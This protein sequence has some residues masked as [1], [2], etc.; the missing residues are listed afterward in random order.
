MSKLFDEVYR[1]VRR[2]PKGKVS[3]YGDIAA[4]CRSSISARTVGWAMSGSPTRVPWHRG[5]QSARKAFDRP[6]FCGAHGI[7]TRPSRSRRHNFCE[8]RSGRDREASLATKI[9]RRAEESAEQPR[10]EVEAVGRFTSTGR[11]LIITAYEITG[12]GGDGSTTKCKA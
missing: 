12:P 7:A 4:M 3:S 2:V 5:G 9:K 1:L 8:V 6:P 11:Y 10:E